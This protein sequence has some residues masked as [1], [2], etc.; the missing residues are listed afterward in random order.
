ML[1][2]MTEFLKPRVRDTVLNA[3]QQDP[4]LGPGNV[5][6]FHYISGKWPAKLDQ[7][8]GESNY[9]W[10]WGHGEDL[11]DR[12]RG[13]EQSV[14]YIFRYL[15]KQGPFL[16]IMGFSMGAAMGAIIASLLEKRHSI[17]DLKFDVSCVKYYVH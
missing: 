2:Y 11:D 6:E 4:S 15:D 17:G 8:P 16:G 1:Q 12:V 5:V 9:R 3:L 14:D 7:L 10:S 13:L